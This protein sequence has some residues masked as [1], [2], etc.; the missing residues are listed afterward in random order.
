MRNFGSRNNTAQHM[1]AEHFS[2]VFSIDG[3]GAAAET[4]AS[5]PPAHDGGGIGGEKAPGNKK[6]DEQHCRRLSRGPRR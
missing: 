3:C 6:M 5:Q 2:F 4:V 1:V